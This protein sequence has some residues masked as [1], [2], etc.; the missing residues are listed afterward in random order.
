MSRES[1]SCT[2]PLQKFAQE[3][4]KRPANQ[5]F[6]W[7]VAT[8][9][10]LTTLPDGLPAGAVAAAFSDDGR[11]LAT[12][13]P[14]GLIQIWETATWT[15][16][17][18]HRGH[19]DRVSALAFAADGR[20]FSGGLDTTVL[21]WDIR[22]PKSPGPVD[23]SW[24]AL[25]KPESATAFKAQGQFLAAPADAVKLLT[26]K[27]KPAGVPDAKHVA[28]LLA[29]LDSSTFANR[30]RGSKALAEIGHTALPALRDFARTTKSPEAGKRAKDLIEQIDGPTIS[31]K[32]LRELR[33]ID[34]LQWIG[35][36]EAKEL[37]AALASGA[38]GSPIT[39]AA[40]AAIRR[41]K[42][43]ER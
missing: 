14:E 3:Q 18:E 15:I 30:E 33:A 37:L 1:P 26:S 4:L 28:T 32:E 34:V 24:D 29:D 6:V 19:R 27:L 16:R 31:A 25:L 10:R 35:S 36:A 17:S 39:F 11:V 13:T 5:I 20:L 42:V 21:A 22:P 8:G 2:Q 23:A 38:A 12:A 41:L 9:K 43:T 40:E 7:D